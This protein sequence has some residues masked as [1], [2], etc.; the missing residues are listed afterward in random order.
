MTRTTRNNKELGS[1]LREYTQLQS[2]NIT[3]QNL[4]VANYEML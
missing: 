2:L 4:C 3:K 1:Y